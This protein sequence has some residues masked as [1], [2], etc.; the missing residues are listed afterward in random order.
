MWAGDTLNLKCHF[1]WPWNCLF[2]FLAPNNITIF[3][4]EMKMGT[5]IDK[6]KKKYEN[7]TKKQ[8]VYVLR[9]LTTAIH[10]QKLLPQLGQEKDWPSAGGPT[11]LSSSTF[12]PNYLFYTCCQ[13]GVIICYYLLTLVG[14]KRS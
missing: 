3:P 14:E 7:R 12:R 6:K 10:A 13:D 4:F 8:V 1:H 9:W 2:Q 5:I 11:S